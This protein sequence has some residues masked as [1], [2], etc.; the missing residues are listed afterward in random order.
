M[1]FSVMV[2]TGVHRSGSNFLCLGREASLLSLHRSIL[3]VKAHIKVQT[4]SLVEKLLRYYSYTSLINYV[5]ITVAVQ[6]KT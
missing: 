5:P 3:I 2:E 4:N 1:L 6:P